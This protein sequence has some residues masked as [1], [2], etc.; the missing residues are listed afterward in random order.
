M[1]NTVTES[2]LSNNQNAPLHESS[3][4]QSSSNDVLT[5][6]QLQ[7]A[8]LPSANVELVTDQFG[9]LNVTPKVTMRSDAPEFTPASDVTKA[10]TTTDNT[11]KKIK[12]E[13]IY[14]LKKFKHDYFVSD[15]SCSFDRENAKFGAPTGICALPDD[16]LL[17]A[18]FDRDSVLLVDIKGVVH[19]IFKDLPTP[20]AVIFNAAASPTQA[21][22]ATRKEAAILDLNTNKVVTRSKMRGFYPW[23]IQYVEERQVYAACDPSGERIVFLDNN[24]AEIGVWSFHDSTQDHLLQ[25]QPQLYQKVYPYAAYF[26]PNDTSF[27]LTHRQD[28]C[29]LDEYDNT[30]A[31]VKSAYNIPSLQSYSIYVDDAKKC[32]IPDKLNHRLVS[33]DKD[34]KFEEYR[35]KSIQEPYSLTFLS[36]GTLCVTDWNKSHGTSGGI[37]II[38]EVNLKEKQ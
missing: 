28:K 31:A 16:R 21:V 10:T 37:S 29:H 33:V 7:T 3:K 11:E 15:L 24:L 19:H 17:V 38:S 27:V 25:S 32:L 23:N 22:V 12:A 35:C 34:S 30:S 8:F 14:D 1:S 5:E 9:T 20:K 36:T 2:Q 13:F 4:Q 18:N 26:L 6:R